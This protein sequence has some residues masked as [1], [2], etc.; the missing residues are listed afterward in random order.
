MKIGIAVFGFCRP[1]ALKT[2]LEALAR[3]H[4]ADELPLHV[5]VD[6]PRKESQRLLVE[7]TEKVAREAGGFAAIEVTRAQQN[8][9]LA[10]S[11][12]KG[13]RQLLQT[14]DALIV[15]EDDML[16]SPWFLTYMKEGLELYYDRPE[17]AS[18]HGYIYPHGKTLPRSFFIRGADCWGWATWKDRFEL[19]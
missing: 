11:I 6:A 18:L 16:T 1:E 13:V 12:R 3:N 5:F 19:F 10:G 17:V 8:Q 7:S 15:L 2:T 9:G 14:Y 4:G